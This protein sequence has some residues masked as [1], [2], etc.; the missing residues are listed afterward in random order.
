MSVRDTD[1]IVLVLP[2][3]CQPCSPISL[4]LDLGWRPY[5]PESV[6]C[7]CSEE[8]NRAYFDDIIH[9]QNLACASNMVNNNS[10]HASSG[11]WSVRVNV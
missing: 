10:K 6:F 1:W 2:I 3:H 4:V 11:M 8:N 7:L 9:V 5:L